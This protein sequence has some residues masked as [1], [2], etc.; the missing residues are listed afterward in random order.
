MGVRRALQHRRCVSLQLAFPAVWD[1]FQIIEYTSIG[2]HT[3]SLYAACK[4]NRKHSPFGL[5]FTRGS[6]IKT[7]L[8]NR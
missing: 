1:A 6:L 2:I 3:A 4:G 7:A 5:V 8:G